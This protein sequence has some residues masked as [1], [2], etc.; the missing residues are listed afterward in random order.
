MESRGPDLFDEGDFSDTN[1]EQNIPSV[2][3][4]DTANYGASFT[5]GR[6][7]LTTA[8]RYDVTGTTGAVSSQ[9]KYNIAGAP[10]AQID[11]LGRTVKISYAD[12]FND[13]STTRNTYAY[14]TRLFDPAGNY[15]E[16]KYR[17]DTGANAWARSPAPAGNTTDK[18]TTREYDAVGRLLKN[19]VVNSGAYTRYEYPTNNIQSKVFSTIVDS[20]NDGADADDEVMS[21]SWTDG[22]GRVRR[23][24]TEHP[25]STGG[26]SATLAEYD[27]LGQLKR[28]TVPT[29]TNSSYEPAGDDASRGWLWSQNEYDWKGRP[30][31]TIPT[32][33]TGSDGKDQLISYEGCGCAGGQVTTIQSEVVPKDTNP[34]ET[35]R[36]TQKVY[37]DVL[38]RTY[39]TEVLNWTGA[40]YS[41][42]VQTFNG[43]DQITKTRQYAGDANSTSYQDVTVTYDGHGRMKTRHYPVED[44]NTETTWIYNADDS[45][46][47]T[48]DPRGA[49][50]NFTYNELRLATQ[51]SYDPPANHPEI[52]DVP[53]VSFNYDAV[54]N[55]TQMT[56]GTGTTGYFYDPLSRLESEKKYFNLLPAAPVPDHKYSLS[57]EYCIG[58]GLKTVTDPFGYTINY[59]NDKSGRVTAVSGDPT[60]DN[61][62]GQWANGIQ[63]RAF[64]QIKQMTYAIPD[65]APTIKLEY[66]NRLRADYWEI[67]RSGGFEAKADFT[68]GSDSRVIA[69]NDLL[70][71]KWDRSMKYDFAGRLTHNQFGMGQSNNNGNVRVYEQAIEYDGFSMMAEREITNWGQTGGFGESYVN[72]RIQSSLV[73]YDASGNVVSQPID[74]MPEG[75]GTNTFDAAGRRVKYFDQRFGRFNGYLNM[76]QE[77]VTEYDFDGDGRPVVE[78]DN[79]RTYPRNDPPSGGLEAT[80]KV[81]QLWSSVLGSNLVT[82]GGYTGG[83][84]IFAGGTLIGTANANSGSRWTTADPVTGT[85][86][87]WAGS[88]G[89][90]EKAA[91][92]TEPLG[93]LVASADPDLDNDPGYDYAARNSAFPQWQCDL[94]DDVRPMECRIRQEIE[95]SLNGT[96]IKSIWDPNK[97]DGDPSFIHVNDPPLDSAQDMPR[98]VT[99][100]ATHSTAKP[101]D[102][103]ADGATTVPTQ[104]PDNCDGDVDLENYKV[105]IRCGDSTIPEDFKDTSYSAASTGGGLRN[106]TEEE[107][108]TLTTAVAIA[109]SVLGDPNC[110]VAVQKGISDSELAGKGDPKS[111]LTDM[112]ARAQK[113]YTSIPKGKEYASAVTQGD[114]GEG[115]YFLYRSYEYDPTLSAFASSGRGENRSGYTRFGPSFFNY[116]TPVGVNLAQM[117]Q[118]PAGFAVPSNLSGNDNLTR[119]LILLHEVR[120]ITENKSYHDDNIYNS[121]IYNACFKNAK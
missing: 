54:G 62:T 18:E 85:T 32:D 102:Q 2:I 1:P 41:T 35:A 107:W 38:G 65:A 3:M 15:S 50:T 104:N 110:G 31:R 56:D 100:Q 89:V 7:N 24:R 116:G 70:D 51:I 74:S 120:V 5:V 83:T 115:F 73:D 39:K 72:G 106:F 16:V 86:V 114:V 87:R 90:W 27:I 42:T 10:V 34:N 118:F 63:Y 113:N 108:A 94:P 60:A 20:D 57:Y 76:V 53:T 71:D 84:K 52:P 58:G 97:K 14:P 48:I 101:I 12:N 33:S 43:R 88:N 45:V 29:E 25:G 13:T 46:Q 6:G 111:I 40:V 95:S 26:W 44:A 36:R 96:S 92:E 61:P 55:R 37:Q 98:I 93:Q 79:Q 109:Q 78:K 75:T 121:E 11:P 22:A 8:T 119:A 67:A 68:H 82:I 30:T 59:T 64:G 21:E 19:T 80:P 77:H 117:L 69:K 91:E 105:N 66:D 99:H 112:F 17:F 47:Q 28:S 49:I 4:H 103:T 9:I 23:S 81:F